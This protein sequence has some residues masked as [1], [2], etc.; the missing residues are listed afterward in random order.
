MTADWY[1]HHCLPQVQQAVRSWRPK[2]G[3]TLH[4]DNAPAHSAT[5]IREFLAN[6]HV[7]LMSHPPYSP[8]LA[9]GNFFAFP[10][11]KKQL[12]RSRYDGPKVAI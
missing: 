10:R 6:K 2:S 9:P 12:R 5:A 11:V 3:I 4:H 8:D 7:Q 1:V